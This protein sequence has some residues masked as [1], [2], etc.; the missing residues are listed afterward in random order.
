MTFHVRCS[1][2]EPWPVKKKTR[3]L[4][5]SADKPSSKTTSLRGAGERADLQL[6]DL[7]SDPGHVTL[8][9]TPTVVSRTAT[10]P[11]QTTHPHL[12]VAPSAPTFWSR[13]VNTSPPGLYTGTGADYTTGSIYLLDLD[14][15]SLGCGH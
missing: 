15:E 12:P 13:A 2:R 11:P 5:H 6:A 7:A 14:S 9:H 1:P 4:A 3:S 10:T 8:R